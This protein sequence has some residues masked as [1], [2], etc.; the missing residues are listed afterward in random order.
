MWVD[1]T[2][3][4]I[5]SIKI[6]DTMHSRNIGNMEK[7]T[8]A[9]LCHQKRGLHYGTLWYFIGVLVTFSFKFLMSSKNKGHLIS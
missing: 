6:L 3:M 4:L 2:L 7:G 1:L 9:T 5:A 8:L